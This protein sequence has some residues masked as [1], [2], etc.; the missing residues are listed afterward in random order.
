MLL[1]ALLGWL[2]REQRDVIAFLLEENR[3]LKAQLSRRR[4]R[5]DDDQRRPLAVFG[6]QLGRGLLREFA[7]LVTPRR[8]FA[9]TVSWWPGKWTYARQLYPLWVAQ[10]DDVFPTV[11]ARVGDALFREA[12]V[13]EP[14]VLP[15]AYSHLA[16]LVG[17]ASEKTYRGA[18]YSALPTRTSAAPKTTDATWEAL[19]NSSFRPRSQ[20]R[21]RRRRGPA[22]PDVAPRARS[23]CGPQ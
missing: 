2:D 8:F 4:L 21:P 14:L 19:N 23:R 9:G 3:V 16:P 11:A 20:G 12:G 18:D 10:G 15:H 13:I 1:A 5:L 6:E 22:E 17:V 7:T